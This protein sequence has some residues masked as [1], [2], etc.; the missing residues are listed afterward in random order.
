MSKTRSSVIGLVF[1]APADNNR[2]DT[3]LAVASA[4]LLLGVVDLLIDGIF[5]GVT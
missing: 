1:G 5:Q 2:Q 4:M 3:G